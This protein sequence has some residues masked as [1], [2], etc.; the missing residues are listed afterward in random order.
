MGGKYRVSSIFY[1]RI[2]Q[3]SSYCETLKQSPHRSIS[4]YNVLIKVLRTVDPLE[5]ERSV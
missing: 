3:I 1:G 5:G 2:I 4:N